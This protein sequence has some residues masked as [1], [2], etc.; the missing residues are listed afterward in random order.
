MQLFIMRHG[1]ATPVGAEDELRPLTAAGE[2][3]VEQMAQWANSQ[4]IQFDQV[5]V[6]PFVRAKQTRDI[7]FRTYRYPQPAT[8]ELALITPF[9]EVSQVH[10]YLDFIIGERQLKN[11]LIISHMP[12]VS[13]LSAEL[14]FDQSAPIFQTAAILQVNYDNEKM[15]GDAMCLVAP[16]DIKLSRG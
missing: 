12:L 4:G 1:Q 9:G 5:L 8:E 10:D 14:T 11:V 13:F 15:K 3:E 7:F 6:S 16:N 2:A